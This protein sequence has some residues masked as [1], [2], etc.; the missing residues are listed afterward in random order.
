MLHTF[1]NAI[2]M[3]LLAATVFCVFRATFARRALLNELTGKVG[4]WRVFLGLRTEDLRFSPEA[5]AHEAR[6]NRLNLLAFAFAGA[7]ALIT[8]AADFL[9]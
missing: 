6:S 5:R 9:T 2:Q 1:I 4:Y 7:Y 3:L 8:F